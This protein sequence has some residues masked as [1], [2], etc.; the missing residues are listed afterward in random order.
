[1]N[2]PA[3]QRARDQEAR[4][5]AAA[6]LA[7]SQPMEPAMKRYAHPIPCWSGPVW[8]PPSAGGEGMDRVL[9]ELTRQNQLLMDLLGAVNSL[10]AA[11]LSIRSRLVGEA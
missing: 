5:R 11:T 1:M 7:Q 6:I 2:Q 8:S 3:C 9:E 4:Q 10:T